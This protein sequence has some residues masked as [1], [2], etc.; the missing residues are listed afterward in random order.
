MRTAPF[1]L[2]ALL[3]ASLTAAAC[4]DGPLPTGAGAVTPRFHVGYKGPDEPLGFVTN[5]AE[6]HVGKKGDRW[7]PAEQ[8]DVK[9][10]DA[11]LGITPSGVVTLVCN[12]EVPAGRPLPTHAEV[13]K[14]VLCFLPGQR[15]TRDAQEVFTPSGQI[16]LTCHLNPN[17]P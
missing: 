14:A 16:T 13:E 15:E 4:Q 8:Y 9:T 6:C 10:F 2:A 5:D 17:R 7:A 11:H 3:L 12:G 1:T